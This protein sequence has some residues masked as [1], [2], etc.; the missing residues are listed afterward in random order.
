[1]ANR[2]TIPRL[3]SHSCIRMQELIG[4]QFVLAQS[5]FRITDVRHISGA[6]MVYAEPEDDKATGPV[7]RRAFRF[8][9]IAHLVDASKPA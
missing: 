2:G 1:M 8:A 3:L 5:P 4:K 6:C 9:D 7:A